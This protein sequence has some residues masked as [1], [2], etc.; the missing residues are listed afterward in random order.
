MGYSTSGWRSSAAFKA[1]ES[2]RRKS[3]LNCGHLSHW[4]DR[5]D[6]I[7]AITQYKMRGLDIIIGTLG[8][9]PLGA[10]T[11]GCASPVYG[12]DSLVTLLTWR[13]R[14]S[15]AVDSELRDSGDGDVLYIAWVARATLDMRTKNSYS[16]RPSTVT[17]LLVRCLKRVIRTYTV[18]LRL[19]SLDTP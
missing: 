14:E 17:I 5:G 19:R 3:V 1:G 15:T 12:P 9:Y 16:R 18:A 8:T 13:W 7:I 11:T 2:C 6:D 10:Y 4:S